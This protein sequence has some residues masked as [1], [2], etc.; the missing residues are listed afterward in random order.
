MFVCFLFILVDVIFSLVF[1]Q[2]KKTLFVVIACVMAIPFAKNLIGYLMIIKYQPL[3]EE[4]HREAEEIAEKHGFAMA[5]DISV[6]AEAGIL[7]YPC[8]AV[9]NNNVIGLLQPGQNQKKKDAVEY[10]KKVQERVNTKPRVIVVEKLKDMDRELSR[11]NP[12][13]ED[14]LKADTVIAERLLELGL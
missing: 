14:Q 9:F 1:F 2:T 3:D 5:Y 4:Q 6:T 11:L 12:P 7:F 8:V 10:L 13:K